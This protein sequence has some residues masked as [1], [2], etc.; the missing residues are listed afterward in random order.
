MSLGLLKRLAVPFVGQHLILAVWLHL[1]H[2]AQ[3]AG[4][5]HEI[6]VRVERAAVGIADI[7]QRFHAAIGIDAGEP[8]LLLVADIE[9]TV[10]VPNRAFGEAEAGGD[11]F[12]LA[13]FGEKLPELWADFGLSANW[14]G[15][16]SATLGEGAAVSLRKRRSARFQ[17]A[18]LMFSLVANKRAAGT[19]RGQVGTCVRVGNPSKAPLS[20]GRGRS[21]PT[22]PAAAA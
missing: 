20:T 19:A 13:A 2:G 8:V 9:K 16:A 3:D 15:R 22:M 1:D 7:E 5:G 10:R 17:L 6:P 18:S 14:P 21:C 4:G 12:Q 11:F